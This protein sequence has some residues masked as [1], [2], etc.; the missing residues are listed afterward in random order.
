[1]SLLG[2]QRAMADLAASPDL[3]RAARADAQAALAGYDLTPLEHRRVASAAAQRGMIINCRLHRS[4]RSS[5]ILTLLRGTVHL[6]GKELR[7]TMDRFWAAYPTPDFT[8]RR[9]IRRSWPRSWS[10]SWPSTS[11][12]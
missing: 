4:N 9:E 7:A 10:G 12:G 2:F 5:T 11:W 1:M 6:L 8:T 3:C